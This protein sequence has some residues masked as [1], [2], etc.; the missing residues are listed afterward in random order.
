[1]EDV[2]AILAPGQGAQRQ[3]FLSPWLSLAGAAGHLARLSDAAGIDLVAAGTTMSDAE[4]TDTAIAQPLIVAA[5][6]MS[7]DVLP[8]LPPATVFAG[9]SVGEFAASALAGIISDTDA[10]R[11]VAT[12]GAAMAHASASPQGGMT[13]LLGGDPDEVTQ[14]VATAGASIANYNAKGQIVA[15]GTAEAL[16]RLADSPPAGARLRP[17]A[18]AGAFHTDLMSPARAAIAAAADNVTTADTPVGVLSN[19]DGRLIT[20][21]AEMLGR[22][23]AQVCAP[24]RWDL[25][26][27][28]LGSMGVTAV[29]ELAPAGTLTAL[30]RRE[31]P[32]VATLALRSPDD[33]DAA[34]ALINEHRA[35]LTDLTMPWQLLVAPAR[36]TVNL[37]DAA[38]HATLTAGEVVVRVT[39]RT[40]DLEVCAE[41]DGHLVEWLVHDGDPV[42]AG[43]PL[44]RVTAEVFA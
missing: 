37:P 7:A 41:R 39:T 9:H 14:A 36:G 25:C 6:L 11:L 13:A 2:L 19:V 8:E 40:E 30:I 12:R 34:R 31:L 38:A 5:S 4:I 42:N 28:T 21:G 24:V 20:S 27:Q 23:V 18:V 1:V 17:L 16:A 15:A 33:L 32:D 35:E 3:G 29:I 22:L 10:M 43:Q 44:A 26:M